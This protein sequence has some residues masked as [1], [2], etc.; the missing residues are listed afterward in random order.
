MPN[1]ATG[2][3]C[4]PAPSNHW[5][6]AML[7]VGLPNERATA[8]PLSSAMR[9]KSVVETSSAGRGESVSKVPRQKRASER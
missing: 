6:S 9:W 4:P 8:P 2:V 3:G 1:S 7:V 5:Q